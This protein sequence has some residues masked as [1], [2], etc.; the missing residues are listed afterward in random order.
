MF[1]FQFELR[2][3]VDFV[4]IAFTIFFIWDNWGKGMLLNSVEFLIIFL[5]FIASLVTYPIIA[6]LLMEYIAFPYG[7]ANCISLFLLFVVFQEVIAVASSNV[8]EKIPD[9][10]PWSKVYNVFSFLP[11]FGSRLMVVTHLVHVF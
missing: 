2:Y 5:A 11:L 3:F 10:W 9:K 1:G 6:Q 4:I 7:L 8:V